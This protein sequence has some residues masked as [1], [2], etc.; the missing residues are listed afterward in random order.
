MMYR[1]GYTFKDA[2]QERV[3]A[4]RMRHVHFREL[5]GRAV[6]HGR[7][8]LG[9]EEKGKGKGKGKGVR[10]Q[11]DPERT[12][13]LEVLPYRSIQVGISGDVGRVWREEW[14]V[15]IEDVTGR[16]R[17]LKEEIEKEGGWA[18]EELVE[19]GLVPEEK[20]Y[21]VPDDLRKLLQMDE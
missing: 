20:V 17:R 5:L 16:A 9:V 15:G 3:L 18:L 14:I 7:R 2:G 21:D 11:W 12:V 1:S 4:I 10:V 6:V 8:K 13:W 19:K